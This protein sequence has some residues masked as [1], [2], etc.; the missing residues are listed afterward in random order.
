MNKCNLIILTFVITG[1]W[2]IILQIMS[3]NYNNLPNILKTQLPFIKDLQPY[4]KHHT[5]LAAFLLAAI[6]GAVSQFI[7]INIMPFPKNFNLN[8]II[9]LLI[10]SFIVSSLFG[11]IMQWSKLFPYLQKYY[12]DKL[13]VIRGMYHDG[14][15]GLIVQITLLFILYFM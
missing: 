5:P 9:K 11:F 4:F 13:G 6:T 1:I 3:Y 2:D 7:I 10:I 14:I 8:K 12:Y 15:S